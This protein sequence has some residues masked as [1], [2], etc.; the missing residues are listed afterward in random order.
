MQV[1]DKLYKET[2]FQRKS[3]TILKKVLSWVREGGAQVMGKSLGW[4]IQEGQCR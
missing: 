3:C 4:K 1:K 2:P